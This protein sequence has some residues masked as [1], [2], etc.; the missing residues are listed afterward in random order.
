CALPVDVRGSGAR[1]PRVLRPPG[2]GA[3]GRDRDGRGRAALRVHAAS[4]T[5]PGRAALLTGTVLAVGGAALAAG[6]VATVRG[7]RADA[8]D[9]AAGDLPADL[10]VSVLLPVRDEATRVAACLSALLAQEGVPRLEI[11][12]LDDGSTDGTGD[13]VRAMAAEDPRVTVLVGGP[14]PPGW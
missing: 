11:L 6:N 12:V 10:A 3:A 13:I 2:G 5:S 14:L 1:Q 4:M 7:A 9:V 8:A